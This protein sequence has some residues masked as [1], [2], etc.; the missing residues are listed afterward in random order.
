MTSQTASSLYKKLNI[1]MG[2][3][4]H[5]PKDARNN[6]HNY[7][8]VSANAVATSIRQAMVDVNLAFSASAVGRELVTGVTNKDKKFTRWIIT[9]KF[10]FHDPDTGETLECQWFGEADADDDKGINKAN[11]AAE[12]YFLLKM[13]IVS[14]DD[15]P[16][17]DNDSSDEPPKKKAPPKSN[18]DAIVDA[19]PK[20]APPP[21]PEE[22]S[23]EFISIKATTKM[24]KGRP[25]VTLYSLDEKTSATMW[26]RAESG[27]TAA[28][29]PAVN[30]AV[31][32]VGTH[33]ISAPILVRWE[34]D[35]SD[36][37]YRSVIKGGITKKSGAPPVDVSQMP[38]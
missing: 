6:F 7:P 18:A 30:D 21:N 23:G 29:S 1:V 24:S 26:S 11:T 25:L 9:Y 19:L 27:F 17:N 36:G 35:K 32:N 20:L 8:F 34:Y 4:N 13:F 37:G 15:E 28:V 38:D 16:D 5:I 14:T 3:V 10:C 2:V 33:A 31:A 12:K 22:R